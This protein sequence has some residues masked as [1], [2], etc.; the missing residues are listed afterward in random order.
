[1][2]V[3]TSCSL[4]FPQ[5]P[6][7]LL[8][9]G[10]PHLHR[11]FFSVGSYGIDGSRLKCCDKYETIWT[12]EKYVSWFTYEELC[13]VGLYYYLKNDTLKKTG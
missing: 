3:I 8:G 1:M 7:I 13:I 5:L 11:P 10:V 4:K 9:L 6:T 12:I 2:V